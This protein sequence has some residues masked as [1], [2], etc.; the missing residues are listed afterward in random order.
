[1]VRAQKSFP[2]A[3]TCFIDET[4]KKHFGE[5]LAGEVLSLSFK[6]PGTLC[7]SS[8]RLAWKISQYSMIDTIRGLL[9]LII[10]F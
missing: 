7:R 1:V 8:Q 4:A 2:G 6:V 9:F 10:F 5:G 3:V